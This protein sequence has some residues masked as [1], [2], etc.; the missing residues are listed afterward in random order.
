MNDARALLAALWQ[1]RFLRS[2]GIPEPYWMTRLNKSIAQAAGQVHT[3][4]T[5]A[6]REAG[7]Y[8]KGK[9]RLHGLEITI[10]N[11][12]GSIRRGKGWEATLP[13]HYG[14]LNRTEGKDGDHVDCFIGPHP[15]SEMVFV[16]D[17]LTQGGHFDEHKC[18]L[19]FRTEAKAKAG[20]LEAYP[21]GWRCGPITPMTIDQFREW[22]RSGDTTK[23]VRKQV[24]KYSRVYAALVERYA[25]EWSHAPKG[26]MVSNV[27]GKFYEGG[28]FMPV[29]GK[30]E[31][32]A[33]EKGKKKPAKAQKVLNRWGEY[34]EVPEGHR[35][36]ENLVGGH[37]QK[38]HKLGDDALTYL[39][40]TRKHTQQLKDLWEA[41]HASLPAAVLPPSVTTKGVAPSDDWN[42]E[43]KMEEHRLARQA[44]SAEKARSEAMEQAA[45]DREEHEAKKPAEPPK[46]KELFT[47]A[48]LVER[49][50]LEFASR[51]FVERY[52][53][54]TAEESKHWVTIGGQAE[55]DKKHVGGSPVQIDGSGK[56]TAGPGWLA[57]KGIS[58]LG[59][60]PIAS[61]PPARRQSPADVHRRIAQQINQNRIQSPPPARPAKP[62][63]Q[64]P[65]QV[66][67]GDPRNIGAA[68]ARE[69]AARRQRAAN[70]RENTQVA[71]TPP[72]P[73]DQNAP[74]AAPE[75]P[76]GR[77]RKP[78]SPPDQLDPQEQSKRS[79]TAQRRRDT[80]EANLGHEAE[81]IDQIAGEYD[82]S[83]DE[84]REAADYLLSQEDEATT[85]GSEPVLRDLRARG[86]NRASM[87]RAGGPDKWPGFDKIAQV[88]NSNH[89][90]LLPDDDA[91]AALWDMLIQGKKT[92]P[93]LSDSKRLRQ[94]AQM[95]ADSK[96]YETEREAVPFSRRG[97]VERYLRWR[98]GRVHFAQITDIPT[99]NVGPVPENS[100]KD[101]ANQGDLLTRKEPEMAHI[102]HFQKTKSM[103]LANAFQ[104]EFCQRE[105]YA[106]RF[107]P[108]AIQ[109]GL[110]DEKEH[111]RD[112]AGKFTDGGGESS[113]DDKPFSLTNKPA[114]SGPVAENV[115]TRQKQ[116][117]SGLDALPGQQ[118]L[119]DDLDKEA[120]EEPKKG[121]QDFSQ[122]HPI[123]DYEM[124]AILPVELY[125]GLPV[126]GDEE[127]GL[128]VRVEKR[129][130][131]HYDVWQQSKSN[132]EGRNPYAT[133]RDINVARHAAWRAARHDPI[134][135]PR[136]MAKIIENQ[137]R[138]LE[139]AKKFG[140]DVPERLR[141]DFPDLKA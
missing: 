20:Y 69:F 74:N 104:E 57:K 94:A 66:P 88:V 34:E 84:L 107:K 52:R 64:V 49:F 62:V 68:I 98:S 123:R 137:R 26:G 3:E 78:K 42:I 16:V 30:S 56:I 67:T 41:G 90:G 21:A 35:A 135:S 50:A 14:Y 77:V 48:G 33:G 138:L 73:P 119:F 131:G 59:K 85:E 124:G 91:S 133:D 39:G 87:E 40:L 58:H 32:S 141:A 83:P 54:A 7:N 125:D 75:R 38:S 10:E 8:R 129:D 70:T 136:G 118:D 65:Q 43:K 134:R 9:I 103:L 82:I 113:S 128:V 53:Q 51:G 106:K 116:L 101:S 55:G 80:T 112:D 81:Q 29:H 95:V 79:R 63:E 115:P 109:G 121:G 130:N 92:R 61:P 139:G 140:T 126:F 108:A 102:E 114:K 96:K 22:L 25:I 47:R 110:F 15:E 60:Q 93:A 45:K 23:P 27:N 46:Q 72:K 127:S 17:Q 6:Q 11:P 100:Q 111:P 1:Q 2:S 18:L 13:H 44:E 105:F 24:S 28:E 86:L 31:Q 71:H 89:P 4:P 117:L 37:P 120:L 19:G 132:P 76:A 99:H 12:K 122:F 97:L 5:D 36:V